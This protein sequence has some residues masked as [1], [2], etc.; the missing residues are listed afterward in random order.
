V[1]VVQ[2]PFDLRHALERRGFPLRDYVT[3]VFSCDSNAL[4]IFA[5]AGLDAA[6]VETTRSEEACQ[7]ARGVAIDRINR[8]SSVATGGVRKILEDT[9][10]AF[11]RD[12]AGLFLFES[13][14][15][16]TGTGSAVRW[17]QVEPDRETET[18][19]EAVDPDPSDP[20]FG[21][22]PK[23]VLIPILVLLVSFLVSFLGVRTWLKIRRQNQEQNREVEAKINAASSWDPGTSAGAMGISIMFL[24]FSSFLP[25]TAVAQCPPMS[26]VFDVS[27]SAKEEASQIVRRIVAARGGEGC[28]TRIVAF[29]DSVFEAGTVRSATAFNRLTDSLS[30]HDHTE[31][32][33]AVCT[34][35]QTA[36]EQSGMFVLVSDFVE[37]SKTRDALSGF[38]DLSPRPDSLADAAEASGSGAPLSSTNGGSPLLIPAATAGGGLLLGAFLTWGWRRRREKQR[39]AEAVEGCRERFRRQTGVVVSLDGTPVAELGLDDLPAS[40]VADS[41][42]AP[43]PLKEER[44]PLVG[45]EA[46]VTADGGVPKLELQI[47][48]EGGETS[49]EEDGESANDIGLED[50]W[51]HGDD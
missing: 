9:L 11:Q 28:A 6:W 45:L 17:A 7:Q 18:S 26:A 33:R 35:A 47:A 5:V 19:P 46:D 34:A 12:R 24:F 10:R 49:A 23:S 37:D 48:S 4:H 16:G 8:A 36:R 32:G 20:P 1:Y 3:Q 29:G 14:I 21:T 39:I 43:V 27:I 51:L 42:L 25:H 13:R 44:F 22:A 38:C 30:G 15:L 50:S 41:L 40:I 2:H 31:L